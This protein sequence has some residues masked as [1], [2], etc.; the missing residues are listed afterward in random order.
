MDRKKSPDFPD[1]FRNKKKV[2][3]VHNRFTSTCNIFRVRGVIVRLP[4]LPSRKV[5]RPNSIL[6]PT[7]K[8]RARNCA[9]RLASAK[10]RS[11]AR[12][13]SAGIVVWSLMSQSAFS[14]AVHRKMCCAVP[15]CSQY[16]LVFLHGAG[17]RLRIERRKLLALESLLLTGVVKRQES[18]SSP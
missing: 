11:K 3:I 1:R 6:P 13:L 12:Y 15:V 9:L 7:G 18:T 16:F 2:K 5:R 10:K 17:L 8:A 14:S 4:Y